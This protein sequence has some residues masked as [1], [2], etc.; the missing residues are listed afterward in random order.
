MTDEILDLIDNAIWASGDEMRWVPEHDKRDEANDVRPR[1][2]AFVE[3]FSA[4]MSPLFQALARAVQQFSEA[5]RP[6]MPYLLAA[7]RHQRRMAMFRYKARMRPGRVV[8]L[9]I[10]VAVSR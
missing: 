9:P 7:Q 10:R 6:A 3:A 8:T 1:A 2:V 4:A 5:L